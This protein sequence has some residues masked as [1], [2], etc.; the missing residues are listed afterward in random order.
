MTFF[1]IGL[2][3]NPSWS[4]KKYFLRLLILKNIFLQINYTLLSKFE[5]FI[6]DFRYV[7]HTGNMN[8]WLSVIRIFPDARVGVFVSIT[9]SYD[10]APPLRDLFTDWLTDYVL[11]NTKVRKE[12]LPPEDKRNKACNWH[13]ANISK[14][15]ETNVALSFQCS[16]I[17]I[18]KYEKFRLLSRNLI[19][20]YC[21]K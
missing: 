21:I 3:L 15:T 20:E 7:G 16:K 8:G 17:Q 4:I 1:Y 19:G 10:E 13:R 14:S 6:L 9:N 5:K 11:G 12:K 18:S 2:Q